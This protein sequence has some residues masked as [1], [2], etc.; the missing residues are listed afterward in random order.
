MTATTDLELTLERVF[1][2]P[3]ALVFANW[4]EPE[5]LGA[6][7]APAGFD[8]L[9]SSVDG[10]PGGRWR[11]AYG[12]SSGAFYVEHG[13]FIEV[14]AP[15]RLR[16]TL[17]NE[18]A[19]G[20]V[21]FRT[22]VQVSLSE[23]DGKTTM[24]FSQ[25]GFVARELLDSV[26]D[27]WASCFGRLEHQLAAEREVRALYAEWFRASER[28]DLDASMAPVAATVVSYEHGVPLAYCGV[29]R[30]RAAC[31]LG[32][33]SMPSGLRWDV[34]ELS[35]IIRGDVAVT[36]GLNHMH[37]GGVDMWSRGT[38]VFQKRDGR[39]QMIH[40][41]ASFPFDPSD[42]AAKLNLRP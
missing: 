31:K 21:L 28:K 38:R 7:F 10:R 25:R 24:R 33:D 6:W 23:R 16:F 12:S 5:H 14:L 37:G 42:G 39:W 8:V 29:D 9:E 40:Q 34:P 18:D 4:I 13:E 22:E 26:K 3:R 19:E 15:E 20:R 27:G 30:V 17:V 36:W 2:A 1:D 41:H 32:F 35:V 11:V